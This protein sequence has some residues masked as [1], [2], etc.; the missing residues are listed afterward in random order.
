VANTSRKPR[1]NPRS[2]DRRGQRPLTGRPPRRCGTGS[3]FCCSSG[4]CRST[5]RRLAVGRFLTATSKSGEE[6]RDIEVTIG[7][8]TIRGTLKQPTGDQ[9]Q[10]QFATTRVDD[11]KLVEELEA[12]SVKYN[13]RGRESLAAEILGWIIPLL[14]LV[15]LWVRSSSG[16]RERRGGVMSFA[17]SRAKIYA[18]DEVKVRF[19]GRRGR[20]RGRGTSSRKSV[21]S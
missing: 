15:G 2:G 18:D 6:R 10:T 9:K 13:R 14:F 5:C 16:R 3:P 11:P 7:E 19:H 21:E 1:L 17:R 20:G 4:S 8:Q 12:S